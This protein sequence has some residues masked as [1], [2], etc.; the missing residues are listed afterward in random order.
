MFNLAYLFNDAALI[1]NIEVVSKWHYT[2]QNQSVMK[3]TIFFKTT[4]S[5]GA[6]GEVKRSPLRAI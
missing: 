5:R 4:N 3:E 2:L 1:A 6:Q